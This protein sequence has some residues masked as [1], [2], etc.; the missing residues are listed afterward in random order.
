MRARMARHP[1][2]PNG[3]A[4]AH[5]TLADRFL[6]VFLRYDFNT[7]QSFTQVVYLGKMTKLADL[8]LFFRGGAVVS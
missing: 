8:F 2:R 4:A 3:L 5:R 6:I 7:K 1:D